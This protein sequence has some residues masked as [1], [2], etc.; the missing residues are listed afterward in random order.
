[1]PVL[2]GRLRGM[3]WIVG[4]GVHGYWLG[5][6]EAE[7][8][9]A[10]TRIVSGKKV[11][12]DIGANVGFYSLLSAVL[13]GEQGK[14]FA[15]EPLPRNVEYL[16]RHLSINNIHSVSVLQLALSDSTGTTAFEEAASHGMGRLSKEGS[17]LVRTDTLDR[18]YESGTLPDPEV[19]KIDVEGAEMYVLSGARR[20]LARAHPI[21]F[22]ATHSQELH[23]ECIEF[24][25]SLGYRL[26]TGAPDARPLPDGELIAVRWH[27]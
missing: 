18:L 26:E 27:T 4:S 6:Y 10:F 11:V 7:K 23:K 20:M 3:K 21:I 25:R 15:F 24:L 5:S 16:R 1:M 2:Q 8:Q 14:V 22:L 13:V 12:F 9:R 19:M 17:L